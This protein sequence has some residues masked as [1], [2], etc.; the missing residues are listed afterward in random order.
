L[1]WIISFTGRELLIWVLQVVYK[2]GLVY[3]SLVIPLYLWT[4]ALMAQEE[5]SD[6]DYWLFT[7]YNVLVNLVGAAHMAIP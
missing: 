6:E 7:S 1:L 4:V 2:R 3:I 5:L